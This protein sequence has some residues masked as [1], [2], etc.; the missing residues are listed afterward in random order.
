[1]NPSNIITT[2]HYDLRT[3]CLIVPKPGHT[4]W[5]SHILIHWFQ[6]ELVHYDI[7]TSLSTLCL[8]AFISLAYGVFSLCNKI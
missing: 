4:T 8:M 6:V 1:M 5:G 7:T 3:L 2:S